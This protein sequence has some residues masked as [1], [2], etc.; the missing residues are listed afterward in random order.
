MGA[1]LQVKLTAPVNPFV[2]LTL[3]LYWQIAGRDHGGIVQPGTPLDAPLAAWTA[4][5]FSNEPQAGGCTRR[6]Q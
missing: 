6:A 5:R 3:K 2:P 4:E 1:P